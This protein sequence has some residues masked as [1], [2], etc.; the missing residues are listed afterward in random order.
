MDQ[1]GRILDRPAGL[2]VHPGSRGVVPLPDDAGLPFEGALVN[3]N[4]LSWG[5]D[6]PTVED[7]PT[8]VDGEV[9][10]DSPLGAVNV[11]ASVPGDFYIGGGIARVPGE[12]LLIDLNGPE[13]CLVQ[14]TA[15]DGFNQPLSNSSIFVQFNDGTNPFAFQ[16][17]ST[18]ENGAF[19][20]TAWPGPLYF[21]G[22][23][24]F[25]FGDVIDNCRDGAPRVIRRDVRI[26][27]PGEFGEG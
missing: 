16:E 14:G 7:E 25:V 23:S 4:F 15:Y 21:D 10:F 5:I 18:D 19:S 13:S 6:A 26:T 27:S 17:V 12:P 9:Q 8:D 11:N 3:A 2:A 22:A 24:G 20:F 1:E